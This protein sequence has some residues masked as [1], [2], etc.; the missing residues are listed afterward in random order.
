M[1]CVVPIA[2]RRS[3]LKSRLILAALLMV[4]AAFAQVAPALQCTAKAD[5]IP[6]TVRS[7]GVA[8]PLSDIIVTCTGGTATP[9]T[10]NVAQVNITVFLSV[11]VTSQTVN[12]PFSEVLLIV[13][14]PHSIANPYTPLRPCDPN[15]LMVAI[16]AITG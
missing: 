3:V 7:E 14:E 8:E 5:G 12:L 10:G 6:M 2:F 15:N 4:P 16:C 13:D 11:S 1:V 9:V